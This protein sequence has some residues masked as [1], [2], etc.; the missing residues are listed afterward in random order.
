MPLGVVLGLIVGKQVGIFAFSWL[1]IRMAWADLKAN[2]IWTQFYGV[3][4]R[5]PGP[6]KSR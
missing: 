5:E 4:R 1:T 6:T 3:A 2:T